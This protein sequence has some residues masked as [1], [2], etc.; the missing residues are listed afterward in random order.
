VIRPDADIVKG[1]AQTLDQAKA[2]IEST[3]ASTVQTPKISKRLKQLVDEQNKI[4]HYADAYKP[5]TPTN[6]ST[7]GGGTT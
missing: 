3:L 1:S 7:T 6:P 4:T 5:S 2:T